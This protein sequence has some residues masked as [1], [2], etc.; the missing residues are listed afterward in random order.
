MPPDIVSVNGVNIFLFTQIE[1]LLN[2]I[3]KKKRGILIAINSGKIHKATDVTREII[4]KNIGY[5]DGVGALYAVRG[6]G[7]KKAIVITGCDLWLE[8]T[9]K[10]YRD[11]SFYLVGAKQ[12]VI[13]KTVK[14][15]GKEFPG[16]D[17]KNYRNGYLYAED[18][19]KIL[20]EDII[21]KKPDIIFVGMGSPKQE[22]L[23]Q[24][25]NEQY[26]ALYQG[27]GGSFDIY[28]GALKRAPKWL[29]DH[30]LE[31]FYR[32]FTDISYYRLKR[33]IND[34]LFVVKVFLGVYR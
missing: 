23:M 9:K 25:I 32:V 11:K 3:D 24:K 13:E 21:A 28:T 26:P 4:N 22:F 15:L 12:D 30:R 10:Y 18:E 31:G 17:I 1:E 27:V 20:I 2:F 19:T 33:M 34:I 14:K 8:I 7:H 16:I 29:I 6:K 5:I